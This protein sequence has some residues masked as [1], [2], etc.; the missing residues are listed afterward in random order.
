MAGPTQRMYPDSALCQLEVSPSGGVCDSL[1]I[2]FWVLVVDGTRLL[3]KPK[4]AER[5]VDS[6]DWS[7]HVSQ[8]LF[9]GNSPAIRRGL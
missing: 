5:N 7:A 9:L 1:K 3:E 6:P 8:G 4:G 2:E